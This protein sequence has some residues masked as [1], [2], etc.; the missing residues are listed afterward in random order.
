M[1]I[2]DLFKEQLARTPDSTAV[3]FKEKKTRLRELDSLSN[4]FAQAMSQLGIEKGD[5]VAAIL[6]NCVEFIVAYLAFLKSGVVFVPLNFQLTGGHIKYTLNHSESKALICHEE[7]VPTIKE[8][9]PELNYTHHVISVGA[10]KPYD[11]MLSFEDLLTKGKDEPPSI[12]LTEDD[13]AIF[14]YTAG[15]TG[16]PKGVVHSHFNCGYVAQHWA[17]VFHMAPGKSILMVLPLFHAFAIHCV[18]VPALISGARLVMSEKYSTSWT[19]EA[20]EK[21]RISALPLVPAMA[22]MMVNHED[23]PKVDLSSAEMAL[24][25]GA[26]VPFELLKQWREAFPNMEL[27]NGYGQTESCPC[28]SGLWDVDILEKPRSVGKPWPDVKLKI[29]D[30]QGKELPSP[31]IGEIVY[32]V[33]SVMKQYYKDP[34]LT[35]KTVENGWLHSGDLGYVDSDGYVY[36]VDRKKDII[37]RGGENISSMEVEEVLHQHPAV[38]EASAI[39]APDPILGETVMA[40]VVRKP[41]QELS[42]EELMEFC[43]KRLERFKVPS[44]VEFTD[45]LPRNPG[46]KVLKRELKAR[47]IGSK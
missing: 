47:Y 41:G 36:I 16:D 3:V 15:T 13:T 37:I 26:I 34:E 29:L 40:V 44:R 9:S 43:A 38:L 6:T 19:L 17:R 12:A 18:T 21:Y 10:K 5:R 4:R 39:G 7:F 35:A 25:G 45:Q 23:F 33:P 31:E 24:I 22:T 2:R 30:D 46:G 32:K 8:I 11:G 42:G 27:I 28:C 20:I 14:L 1:L